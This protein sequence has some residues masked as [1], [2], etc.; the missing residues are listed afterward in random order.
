VPL[1]VYFLT[2]RVNVRDRRYANRNSGH[3]VI[4]WVSNNPDRI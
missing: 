1:F 4:D 3:G 2:P